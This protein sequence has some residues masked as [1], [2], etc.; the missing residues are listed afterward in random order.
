MPPPSLP[1]PAPHPFPE[2][3]RIE[4]S[5][6]DAGFPGAWFTGTVIKP[7]HKSPKSKKRKNHNNHHNLVVTVEYETLMS[8]SNHSKKLRETIDVAQIRPRMEEEK[9]ME[10]VRVGDVVDAWWEEGWWEGVVTEVKEGERCE[11]YFRGS[12]EQI[13]FEKRELRVHR[14]WVKGKWVPPIEGGETEKKGKMVMKWRCVDAF[15]ALLP[16]QTNS[17]VAAESNPNAPA[18]SNSIDLVESDTIIPSE[19]NTIIP[20]ESNSV[21]L[22]ESNPIIVVHDSD[23]ETELLSKGSSVEVSSDEDGFQGAWFAATVVEKVGDDKYLIEYKDLRT[24]DDTEF[25]KEQVD[26]L[27]IRPYPPEISKSDRF[28][29]YEE[30]DAL[31]NDG[32]WVGVISKVMSGSKYLVYFKGTNEEMQFKH[33]DL[34][35]HQEWIGGK[36]VRVSEVQ[37]KIP[38]LRLEKFEISIH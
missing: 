36:W 13:E 21:V 28:K 18:E 14:E 20:A 22:P 24:E 4:I 12:G 27:H 38:V 29:L 23:T 2:G 10:T 6:T 25:A 37:Y 35:L 26:A 3:T 19:P 17:N 15:E 31:Y 16:V 33:S 1:P 8:E 34:R 11:V 9:E 32:W 30:V 7:P 5:S